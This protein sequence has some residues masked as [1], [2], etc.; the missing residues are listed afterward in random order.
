[1]REVTPYESRSR[2]TLPRLTEL[3]VSATPEVAT[4]T[5]QSIWAP[6]ITNLT[7]SPSHFSPSEGPSLVGALL[8]PHKYGCSQ[9]E[10]F[11]QNCDWSAE[12]LR[13][14]V[15]PEYLGMSLTGTALS[16]PGRYL[17]VRFWGCW[18]SHRFQM[19]SV[20]LA[21]INP[22][23]YLFLD[24]LEVDAM[25]S[26]MACFP[27]TERVDLGEHTKTGD[28]VGLLEV[29]SRPLSVTSESWPCQWSGLQEVV[30]A[31]LDRPAEDVNLVLEQALIM[32]QARL[33]AYGDPQLNQL[34]GVTSSTG[35]GWSLPFVKIIGPN[36]RQL[37]D[38]V[39]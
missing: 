38:G 10:T 14:E 11:L 30:M 28:I 26:L 16:F 24:R 35:A 37:N 17:K 32:N 31:G 19:L 5:L 2:T 13:L 25:V 18:D 1:M 34:E 12:K 15:E 20:L 3:V 9:L 36:G 6:S 39:L 27:T 22:P 7:F 4:A 29:L 23:V 8:G 33:Q 21:S